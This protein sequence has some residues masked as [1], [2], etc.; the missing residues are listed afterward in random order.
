M[1]KLDSLKDVDTRELS[2]E[3][4]C[5]LFEHAKHEEGVFYNRLNVFLMMETVLLATEIGAIK[6]SI[7]GFV[8]VILSFF[9]LLITVFWWFA[10]I[11]KLALVK[12]LEARL[13]NRF[14]EFRETIKFADEYRIHRHSTTDIL[15][16]ALPLMFGMMWLVLT[17]WQLARGSQ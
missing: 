17:A 14:R 12:T 8:I 15:A 6:D 9:G 3:E 10:Q 7:T 13:Q 16:H 11:N 5:R 4:R 1:A 2:D